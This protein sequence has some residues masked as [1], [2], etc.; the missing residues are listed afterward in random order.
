MKE[1]VGV[2]QQ[3]LQGVVS[4]YT[5]RYWALAQDTFISLI[6]GLPFTVFFLNFG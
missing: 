3:P 1:K 2:M 5:Q 6:I 4:E